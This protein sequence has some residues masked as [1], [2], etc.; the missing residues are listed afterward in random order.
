MKRNHSDRIRVVRVIGRLNVGGPARHGAW[1]NAGMNDERFRSTLVTGTIAPGE[2]DLTDFAR[3]LG[4]EPVV[5]E[6]MSRSVTWKDLRVMWKL[7]RIFRREQP[8]IIHTHTAK[9]GTVGRSAGILYRLTSRRPVRFVHT[10]HGH[11][12]HG[13]YGRIVTAFF[14]FVE[15]T[16][17]R[18][19]DIIVVLSPRQREEIHHH[20]R[21]GRDGQFRI[22]PLGLDTSIGASSDPIASRRTLEVPA[23]AFVA[24]IVGRVTEVKDHEFFL[25]SVERWMSDDTNRSTNALFL[26]I[27]DGHLRPQLELRVRERGLGGRVRFL[28]NRN[29]PEVFYRAFDLLVLTSRN[30]GTPLTILEAMA[31][32]VPVLATAVGGVPDLLGPALRSI[33]GVTLC[34]RGVLVAHSDAAAFSRA[35]SM[36]AADPELRRQIAARANDYVREN[37]GRDRLVGDMRTLYEELCA[38]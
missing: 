27:G 3:H 16:L 21:V 11:V 6:E 12:F 23:T 35:L 32:G 30:E 22:I 24:G 14:L 17:A 1:L 29:D 28:G 8:D 20:F 36:L 5:I 7:F 31:S 15:R 9:A 34:E 4:V 26:V 38:K 37:Y 10:F 2:H 18:F 33:D 25:E 19:T 13:Y